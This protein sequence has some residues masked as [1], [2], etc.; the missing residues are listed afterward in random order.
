MEKSRVLA[1]E[2]VAAVGED[3]GGQPSVLPGLA[4]VV[5]QPVQQL[6]ETALMGAGPVAAGGLPSTLR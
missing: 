2:H 5:G 3:A 6:A 4:R 1:P